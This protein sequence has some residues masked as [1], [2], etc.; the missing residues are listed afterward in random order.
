VNTYSQV[1]GELDMVFGCV[2]KILKRIKN[3]GL[4]KKS[5][6]QSLLALDQELPSTAGT[7]V[8]AVR[9]ALREYLQEE[10]DKLLT[11]LAKRRTKKAKR[12]AQKAC[13]HASS[14]VIESLFGMYKSRRSKNPLNGVTSYVLLLPLLTRIGDGRS[15]STID[16][17][18][19]LEH[20]YMSDLTTWTEDHLTENLA[21]KRQIKLA[22]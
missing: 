6:A 19:S 14:D 13:W 15:A 3:E 16:F 7:R 21:V 20:V 22:A 1:V 10:L 5:V 11:K 17:K 4:S 18:Q 8:V 12:P 2:N 9:Q